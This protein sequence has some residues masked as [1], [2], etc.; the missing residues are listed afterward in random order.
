MAGY[1]MKLL[2]ARLILVLLGIYSTLGPCAT[3]AMSHP[4]H[5]SSAEMDWNPQSNCWEVSLRLVA[6]DLEL[7]LQRLSPQLRLDSLDMEDAQTS[8]VIQDYIQSCFFLTESDNTGS[9]T[10]F[11]I[12]TSTVVPG[13]ISAGSSALDSGLS[14]GQSRPSLST[15]NWVGQEIQ[16]TWIWLY[17]ELV[18]STSDC[19]LKLVHQVLADVNVDQLNIV[20]LRIGQL[21]HSVQSHSQ[22]R[23][24]ELNAH[25]KPAD[26]GATAERDAGLQ[27]AAPNH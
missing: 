5:T 7:A 9:E 23:C 14:G 26:R 10:A 27:P 8:R 22:L 13:E 17:F 24:L 15:I 11:Q 16:G 20:S 25:G 6:S 2:P 21:R 1:S 4:F 18:P 12:S 19:G 3:A